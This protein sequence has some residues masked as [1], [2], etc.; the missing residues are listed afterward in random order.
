MLYLFLDGCVKLEE[1]TEDEV[2][3]F[4]YDQELIVCV[5][6]YVYVSVCMCVRGKVKFVL[7]TR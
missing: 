6:V 1:T 2:F 3:P 7:C 4:K 5:C